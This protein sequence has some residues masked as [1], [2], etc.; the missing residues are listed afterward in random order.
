MNPSNA[1]EISDINSPSPVK[2]RLIFLGTG[3]SNGVPVLGCKCEVCTSADPRDNRLRTSAYLETVTGERILFDIGPD[4]REQSLRHNILRI[5][6]VLVTHPHY[7]HIGGLDDIRQVNF[8]MGGPIDVYGTR[9]TLA[10]IRERCGYMFRVSQEGGGKPKIGLREVE[11]YREFTVR[12]VSIMPFT[13]MH[14]EISILG[15]RIG[16]LVYITDASAIPE[17]SMEVILSRPVKTLV[18]NALRPLPHPTHF[19]LEQAL[20]FISDVSPGYAYLVHVTH[21]FGQEQTQAI[22]PPDV[23]LAYDGL[24]VEF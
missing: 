17:R 16:D 9:D 1:S 22:L 20:K 15:Y 23:M 3:T 8:T 5:D 14:G 4:F 6:G 18:V 21:H 24:T 19:N 2:N 13:V 7:D 12:S 10:E 11:P